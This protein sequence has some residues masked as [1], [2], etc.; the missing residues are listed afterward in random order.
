MRLIVI[1]LVLAAMASAPVLA[2]TPIVQVYFDEQFTAA[3]DC[4]S[5]APGTVIDTLYVYAVN[6]DMFFT[7]IDFSISY[8][9]QITWFGDTPANG[10]LMLGTTISGAAIAWTLPQNGFA[11]VQICQVIM[12][13]QCDACVG[14]ENSEIVVGPYFNQTEVSFT[15]WPDNVLFTA[16]G[17][18]SL[19][20]ATV[21]VEETSW[22]KVKA[23]YQ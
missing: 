10:G 17:M 2:Q 3:G 4:P 23:L 13:W 9:P 7:A 18:R 8:P 12:V 21:P 20:C 11:P 5:D 22:G 16:I 14:N 1:G 19:I 6:F 15:R